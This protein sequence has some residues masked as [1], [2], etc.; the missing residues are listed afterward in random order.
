MHSQRMHP[1]R[2]NNTRPHFQRHTTRGTRHERDD[3]S[4]KPNR[5]RKKTSVAEFLVFTVPLLI[6]LAVLYGTVVWNFYVS[7]TNWVATAPDYTF[8][9]FK[10]YSYLFRQGRFWV[11]VQNNLKW[12]ILG[13]VPTATAAIFL[14]YLL[15]MAPFRASRATSA[16]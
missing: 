1:H 16:P 4:Q 13:V 10:W 9:G 12:L 5:P 2:L 15:E 14:A 8:S 6:F 3:R 11:D 7:M